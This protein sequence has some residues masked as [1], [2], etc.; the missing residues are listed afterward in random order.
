MILTGAMST[1]GL[2][3]LIA[4]LRARRSPANFSAKPKTQESA[5]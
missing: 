2:A 1:G 3:A 4:K 5:S